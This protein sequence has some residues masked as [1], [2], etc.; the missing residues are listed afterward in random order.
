MGRWLGPLFPVRRVAVQDVQRQSRSTAGTRLAAV[1]SFLVIA[2]SA[3]DLRPFRTTSATL[4]VADIRLY[5]E[6]LVAKGAEVLFGPREVPTGRAFNARHPDGP[7][8]EYVHYRP[9]AHGR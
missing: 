6:R 5:Y 2:E 3:R 4:L 8:L 9:D 7:V 1:G